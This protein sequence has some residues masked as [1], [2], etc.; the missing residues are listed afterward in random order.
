MTSHDSSQK[1]SRYMRP[2]SASCDDSPP[3]TKPCCR[4]AARRPILACWASRAASS[5]CA[6]R[7]R[8]VAV[9]KLLGSTCRAPRSSSRLYAAGTTMCSSSEREKS[10]TPAPRPHHCQRFRHL[11][12]PQQDGAA[13][14]KHGARLFQPPHH[15][16]CCTRGEAPAHGG[17]GRK[18]EW[19]APAQGGGT[20]CISAMGP[21]SAACS[22]AAR[23]GRLLPVQPSFVAT[24]SPKTGSPARLS[25][26]PG[27]PQ[28]TRQCCRAMKP[29]V[30]R[31]E[32][33]A[34]EGGTTADL[35]GAG[36]PLLVNL[37]DVGES[38]Q[39]SSAR[40]K[41]Q[42]QSSRTASGTTENSRLPCMLCPRGQWGV[43]L[44]PSPAALHPNRTRGGFP[45]R[46]AFCRACPIILSRPE[47]AS[48]TLHSRLPP[49]PAAFRVGSRNACR[50]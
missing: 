20:I 35:R 41:A 50:V 13:E 34:A 40:A 1:V 29:A 23:R 33:L 48:H 37:D 38:A 16:C 26:P 12:G 30:A 2:Q 10:N 17:E 36:V 8:S 28:E 46:A 42:S 25:P 19:A 43:M 6:A 5:C 21:T 3:Q 22:R 15:I 44:W 11:A 39:Q 27:H 32:P 24:R 49:P 4:H 31:Q 18:H 45:C 9:S 14:V 47:S 7:S